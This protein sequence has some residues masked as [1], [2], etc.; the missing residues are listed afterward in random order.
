MDRVERE[1]EQIR[2]VPAHLLGPR[3]RAEGARPLEIHVTDPD[4]ANARRRLEVAAMDAGDAAAADQADTNFGR[5][6]AHAWV[7]K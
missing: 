2:C 5:G 7:E 3:L 4:D 1:A 6:S